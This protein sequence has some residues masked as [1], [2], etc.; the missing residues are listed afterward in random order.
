MT[1]N[2]AD[3]WRSVRANVLLVG[4]IESQGTRIRVRVG[5]LSAHG[6]L[7]IGDV[8]AADG[9]EVTFRCN[10]VTV[11]GWM[12]WVQAPY[13]GI[14]FGHPIEPE[15]LLRN[16]PLPQHMITRDTRTLD[17]RRPGFRGNQMT[18]E[19]RKIVEEWSHPRAPLDE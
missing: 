8:A 18:D 12:V 4:T 6:A 2:S 19:E 16:D 5:N 1:K 7:V 10:G 15:D 9:A 17:H 13:A 11:Q 14:N 3:E